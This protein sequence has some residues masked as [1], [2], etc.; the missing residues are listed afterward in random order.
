MALRVCA[1][2]SE[3]RRPLEIAPASYPAPLEPQRLSVY[4][5][6]PVTSFERQ[7]FRLA[8]IAAVAIPAFA[9]QSFV[10]EV[11]GHTVTAWLTGT[12]IILNSSTA[13]QTQGGGRIIPASGPLANLFFGALGYVWLRRVPQFSSVRLFLWLFTFANLFIGTGYILFSGVTNFGDAAFVIAGLKPIWLY[14]AALIV[15]GVLGYRF[16]VW[17]A[18]R[19]TFGLVRNGSIAPEDFH[20]ACYAACISGSALYVAASILNPVSRSLILYDGVSA[21]CGITVGLLLLPPIVDRYARTLPDANTPGAPM[22][23]SVAWTIVAS[24][25]AA[26]FLIFLGHGIRIH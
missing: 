3:A 10:H 4:S 12:R 25:S 19:D 6:R 23:F 26:L 16:S 9:L 15:F 20:R 22:P 14:R 21:A 13:M 24:L 17:L 5:F 7:R 11:L 2:R 8:T 18:A 1:I